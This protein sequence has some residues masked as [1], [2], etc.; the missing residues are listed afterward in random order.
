MRIYQQNQLDATETRAERSKAGSG[1]DSTGPTQQRGQGS[2]ASDAFQLS[3]LASSLLGLAGMDSPRR[4]A[5]LEQLS[6]D[7][8]AGRYQV[9][10][11][12]VSRAMITAAFQ[13]AV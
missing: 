9:D 6:L 2:R 7:V 3:S 5:Q 13:P 8:Q 11:T 12:L 1:V 10:A 4:A